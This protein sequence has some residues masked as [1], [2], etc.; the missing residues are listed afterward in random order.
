MEITT[1]E[2]IRDYLVHNGYDGLYYDD[3]ADNCG[4]SIDDLMPCGEIPGDCVA[5]RKKG[6]MFYPVERIIRRR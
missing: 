3:G 2:M 5:A 4:C 6:D 1:K